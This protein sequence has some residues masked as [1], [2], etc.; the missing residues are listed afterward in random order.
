MAAMSVH[1]SLVWQP[2][3]WFYSDNTC[4][5][6]SGA[7]DLKDNKFFHTCRYVFRWN[8]NEPQNGLDRE[9]STTSLKTHYDEIL[10]RFIPWII[11]LNV[12]MVLNW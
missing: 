1:L 6:S 10:M 8:E 2:G 12:I 3:K 11:N 5:Q 9:L 7:A 4:C